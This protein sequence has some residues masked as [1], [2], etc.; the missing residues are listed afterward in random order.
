MF[1]GWLG[2]VV[3][4]TYLLESSQGCRM[5]PLVFKNKLL[6]ALDP[7]IIG[8]LHL[9]Q[10]K[11]PVGQEVE[12]PGQPIDHVIFIE[13]GIGSM[14]TTFHDSFQVEVGLFGYESIM[15]GSALIGTKLSLNKV[16]MQMGGHGFACRTELAVAEYS[17]FGRFHDVV[18]RYQQALLIQACQSVGC[19]AHHVIGQRLA[20]WL[21]LCADRSESSV[22]QLT[23]EYLGD[24]L[25]TNRSTVSSAA[26]QLQSERL[27]EYSRGKV[28]LINRRGLEA[29]SCECYRVVRDHLNSYLEVQQN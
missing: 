22:L 6:S 21:L 11:L 25:G 20:R 18:L 27:I 2:C 10:L 3:Y 8:R 23:H 4:T 9:R 13:E 19:I 17:R 14:T 12:N 1:G 29:R 7:E 16:Y 5:N 26:A 15:G 24:M 28:T